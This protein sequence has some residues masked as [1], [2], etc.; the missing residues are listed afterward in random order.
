MDGIRFVNLLHIL[1]IYTLDIIILIIRT[2]D[3]THCR[4]ASKIVIHGHYII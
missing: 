2:R 1:C 4:V 3:G